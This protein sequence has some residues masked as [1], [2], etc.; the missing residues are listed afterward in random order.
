MQF[1]YM[2]EP[3][4][5]DQIYMQALAIKKK[6]KEVTRKTLGEEL[7]FPLPIKLTLEIIERIKEESNDDANT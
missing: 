5:Y 2:K 4:L 7:L 6:G 3:S 1:N